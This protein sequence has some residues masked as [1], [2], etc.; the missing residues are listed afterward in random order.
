MRKLQG[1]GIGNVELQVILPMA[2]CLS[3]C[4]FGEG[5]ASQWDSVDAF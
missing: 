1:P 4:G 2:S 3:V 5:F